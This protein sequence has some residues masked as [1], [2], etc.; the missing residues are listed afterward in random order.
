MHAEPSKGNSCRNSI[1]SFANIVKENPFRRV[2]YLRDFFKLL[3]A[4]RA[5]HPDFTKSDRDPHPPFTVWTE[6]DYLAVLNVSGIRPEAVGRCVDIA[7]ATAETTVRS[8]TALRPEPATLRPEP[9]CLRSEAAIRQ[10]LGVRIETGLPVISGKLTDD[11][12]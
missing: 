6:H 5:A 10:R 12:D 9:A 8:G 11:T 2:L 4:V 7:A 3:A 1:A